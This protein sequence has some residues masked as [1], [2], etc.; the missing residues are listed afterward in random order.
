MLK[1]LIPETRTDYHLNADA[2]FAL[3]QFEA[4]WRKTGLDRNGSAGQGIALAQPNAFI[5]QQV[6]PGAGRIR[7]V[8]NDLSK[9]MNYVGTTGIYFE[10]LFSERSRETALEL[11]DAAFT[12]PSIVSIPLIAHRGPLRRPL[13]AE[14]LLLPLLDG[15]PKTNHIMGALVLDR[16]M[17]ISK[18]E[19]TI[20]VRAPFRCEPLNTSA[21]NR[22]R[23]SSELRLVIDNDCHIHKARVCK[24]IA[25]EKRPE[26]TRAFHSCLAAL[27]SLRCSKIGA[28]GRKLF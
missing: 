18:I 10:S 27:A 3:N 2:R 23:Q 25:H 7:I 16:P 8:G 13:R 19:F 28:S 24:S 4:A 22:R 26:K 21:P 9:R 6:G 17:D 11:M 5:L 1:D 12:L 15:S 20:L 14:M